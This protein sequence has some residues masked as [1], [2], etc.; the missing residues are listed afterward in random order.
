MTMCIDNIDYR[1][2]TVDVM[3]TDGIKNDFISGV[4]EV[5]IGKK[6]FNIP[7]CSIQYFDCSAYAVGITLV[8]RK[9][10]MVSP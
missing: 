9:V 5:Y 2:Q 1:K 4:N 3:V 7:S 6:R 8:G 10:L